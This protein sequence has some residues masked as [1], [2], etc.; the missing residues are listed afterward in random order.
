MRLLKLQQTP[1][2]FVNGVSPPIW[3]TPPRPRL[4]RTR[5]ISSAP[6]RAY[7]SSELSCA[8]YS[9]SFHVPIL[10]LRVCQWCALVILIPA[11]LIVQARLTRPPP[12]RRRYAS[13]L[14]S[15]I[16]HGEDRSRR[17]CRQVSVLIMHVY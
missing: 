12:V 7:A 15:R 8:S 4:C 10:T 5:E 9:D 3:T 14:R 13:L 1:T 6:D 16:R 17:L 11:S 2:G